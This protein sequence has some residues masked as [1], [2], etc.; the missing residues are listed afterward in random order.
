MPLTGDKRIR[1]CDFMSC[2]FFS[3]FPSREYGQR[4]TGTEEKKTFFG[5]NRKNTNMRIFRKIFFL[6]FTKISY[7]KQHQD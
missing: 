3:F 6:V 7:Q 1:K 5:T 4:I 2:F